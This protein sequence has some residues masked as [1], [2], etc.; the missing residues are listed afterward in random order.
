[1]SRSVF[2]HAVMPHSGR[3]M[4]CCVRRES[5]CMANSLTKT[6]CAYHSWIA[7]AIDR[8]ASAPASRFPHT[9]LPSD[10]LFWVCVAECRFLR[11]PGKTVRAEVGPNPTMQ[12]THHTSYFKNYRQGHHATT[13]SARN[14]GCHSAP[15]GPGPIHFKDMCLG[16]RLRITRRIERFAPH[17]CVR[18]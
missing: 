14:S 1:M 5:T 9:A 6:Q 18:M 13:N 7:P 8:S 16:K 11:A 10:V 4:T 3:R 2:R 12:A 17:V 15:I